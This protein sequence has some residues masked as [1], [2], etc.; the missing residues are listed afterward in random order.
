[1]D[2]YASQTCLRDNILTN[3]SQLCNHLIIVL[4]SKGSKKQIALVIFQPVKKR[5]VSQS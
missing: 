3:L 1:M 2:N 5:S 4:V